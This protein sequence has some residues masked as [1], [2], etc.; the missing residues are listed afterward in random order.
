MQMSRRFTGRTIAMRSMRSVLTYLWGGLTALQHFC[1]PIP[2]ASPQAGIGRAFGPCSLGC[3]YSCGVAAGWNRS[4]LRPFEKSVCTEQDPKE[5]PKAR[6]I[7]AR[8]NAHILIHKSGTG[9]EV[10]R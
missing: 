8:G 10:F 5:A 2:G 7:S 1:G 4:G 3:L 9:G 6:P